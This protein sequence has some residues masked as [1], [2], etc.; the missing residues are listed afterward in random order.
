M[1]LER[2]LQAS[3]KKYTK[4]NTFFLYFILLAWDTCE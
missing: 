3:G 4:I 2:R 1:T